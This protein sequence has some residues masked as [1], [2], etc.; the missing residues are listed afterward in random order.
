MQMNTI[1]TMFPLYKAHPGDSLEKIKKGIQ[2][3]FDKA[4]YDGPGDQYIEP[5]RK[6]M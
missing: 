5:V 4:V 6:G 1:I 3:A 2:A